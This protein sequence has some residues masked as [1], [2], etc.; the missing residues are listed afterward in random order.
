MGEDFSAVTAIGN[1]R[2]QQQD[3]VLLLYHPQNPKYKLM[4]VADGMGGTVDGDKASQEITKQMVG[5]FEGLD[6]KIFLDENSQLLEEEW[7]KKLNEIHQQI[8]EENP[9]S[10]STYVGAIVGETST[11][12]AS[13]GDSRCYIFDSKDHLQQVTVDDNLE[14]LAFHKKW[15]D[16]MK[17]ENRRQLTP[18]EIRLRRSEKDRL[19]FR[20]G[21]NVI[22]RCLGA[23]R[24]GPIQARFTKLKNEAYKA[25]LLFSDGVTDCL[26]DDV[27]YSVTKRTSP[28]EL[29]AKIVDKA[30]TTFSLKPELEGKPEYISRIESGKDNTSVVVFDKRNSQ[31]EEER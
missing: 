19:R 16:F 20:R 3:S 6:T 7:N 18:K 12:I 31:E 24:E 13:I 4:V 17:K 22:T 21:S 8:L 27:L 30:L 25:L 23:K 14:F 11:T 5:W 2:N 28:Q 9:A 15:E 26:D 10:G 29:A 1:S